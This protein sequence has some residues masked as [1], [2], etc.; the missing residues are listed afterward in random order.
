MSNS[1]RDMSIWHKSRRPTRHQH[2][3]FA[4]L[5]AACLT[6]VMTL[7]GR[8]IPFSLTSPHF[9]PP[10]SAI[11][12]GRRTAAPIVYDNGTAGAGKQTFKPVAT[13]T[14]ELFFCGLAQIRYHQNLDS[15]DGLPCFVHYVYFEM[16]SRAAGAATHQ[17]E[18]LN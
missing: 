5:L 15:T 13:V 7:I 18:C 17:A 8:T 3:R 4:Q 10:F 2:D 12:P 1:L 11:A 16:Q 9:S 14:D 6:Q